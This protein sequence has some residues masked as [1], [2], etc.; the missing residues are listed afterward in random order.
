M[1]T[2]D[3]MGRGKSFIT[4]R[5]YSPLTVLTMAYLMIPSLPGWTVV[6]LPIGHCNGGVVSFSFIITMD[7]TLI[8]WLDH[9]F[10]ESVAKLSSDWKVWPRDLPV[11][12]LLMDHQSGCDQE[13]RDEGRLDR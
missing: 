7:P 5:L 3:S 6:T 9:A 4:P 1:V 11:E 2:G 12:S 13:S 8:Q 10:F